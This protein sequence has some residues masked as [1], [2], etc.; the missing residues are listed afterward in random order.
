MPPPKYE[1]KQPFWTPQQQES[2]ELS[3]DK[4]EFALF[5]EPRCGKSK[6]IVD[7]VCY[8]FENPSSPL[9]V[10]GVIIVA[11]PN[12]VHAGWIKDAFP[13]NVPDRIPWKGFIWN[14]AKTSTKAYKNEFV[15]LSRFEGLAVFAINA[16]AV[17]TAAGRKAIDYFMRAR[18]RIALVADESSFMASPGVQRT[19]YMDA[20]SKRPEIRLIRILDGTPV[21][22]NGPFDYFT[23]IRFLNRAILGITTNEEFKAKYAEWE[24]RI[25]H[26]TNVPY[27]V[28]KTDADG[29]PAFRN[30]DD[31]WRRI[32]P[33]SYRATYAQCF[34]TP[35]KVYQK[36][37]FEL[38]P[39]QRR[40]YNE[41]R[42]EFETVIK[43][44]RLSTP[45]A[46]VRMMRLQQI[47]SNY[48]PETREGRLHDDCAGNGC[49]LCDGG[50]VI[51]RTPPQPIA[52]TNPRLA[53]LK[54]EL[55]PG[56]Q[57]IVW[58]RFR[59]DA[60]DVARLVDEMGLRGVR[61]DGSTTA[62]H[63]QE[64]K[65]GFQA[66]RYDVFIGNQRSAGRGIPL[67]KAY[68]HV[69]Y[70]NTFSF[71][72]RTQ[73]EDRAEIGHR[74]VGTSV[75]DLVALD[76]IDELAILPALRAKL[77]V[78]TYIMQDPKRKWI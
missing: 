11:W 78:V 8:Q 43:G 49:D 36:R 29:K 12:G 57:L 37:Y 1:L 3:Y 4:R 7:T 77:D 15:E 58:C 75:V 63:K 5:M 50:V 59:Q 22:D 66:G 33:I 14:S 51:Q 20:L 70:S 56:R 76:T 64:A 2:F 42:D 10:T 38:E 72:D 44:V 74:T 35:R 13:D 17:I 31:L 23:Q 45:Q 30:M 9:H 39:E 19:K 27:P 47:A 34:N 26:K 65:D 18:R 73:A 55:R 48:M 6:P 67:W 61:Y 62:A 54:E 69:F 21:G 53:A 25:N 46:I 68:G 40:A 41:L 52:K 28:L 32:N 16:E 24:V 71:R 60:A